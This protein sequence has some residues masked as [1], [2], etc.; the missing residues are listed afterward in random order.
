[1]TKFYWN[2]TAIVPGAIVAM[3]DSLVTIATLGYCNPDTEMKYWAYRHR[4]DK[5]DPIDNVLWAVERNL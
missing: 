5:D 2:V 1:M 4:Y 3:A